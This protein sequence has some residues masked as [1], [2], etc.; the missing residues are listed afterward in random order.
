MQCAD[1]SQS[2]ATSCL[3]KACTYTVNVVTLYSNLAAGAADMLPHVTLTRTGTM[4]P[5]RHNIFL[6]F[7]PR[8]VGVLQCMGRGGLDRGPP[9]LVMQQLSQQGGAPPDQAQSRELRL[10]GVQ[11]GCVLGK[12]GENIT[13]IRKVRHSSSTASALKRNVIV[14]LE[15][16]SSRLRPFVNCPQVV[17]SQSH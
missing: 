14:A 10:V 3:L 8:C 5:Y 13:Q 11:V 12:A 9:L 15:L 7:Q 1:H 4:Y 6:P 2:L 17:P 16:R